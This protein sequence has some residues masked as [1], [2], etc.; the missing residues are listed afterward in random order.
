MDKAF[1]AVLQTEVDA[2]VIAKISYRGC[3]DRFRY[4]CL[5]CGEEVYLAAADSNE[6]AP[7]FRHRK[8]NNDTDCERYLGHPGALEYYVSVRKHN[9]EQVEFC[10]NRDKMT[11]EISVSFT[12]EELMEYEEKKSIMMV[13][14][15]YCSKPFRSVPLNKKVIVP[16]TKNYFTISEYSNGYLVSFDSGINKYAY[17]D[18]MRTSDKINIFRVRLEDEHC[19]HQTSEIVYTDTEYIAISEN[20]ENIQE[21]ASLDNIVSADDEFSFVTAGI[22]FYGVRFSIKQSD[23]SVMLFF[24][25]HNYQVETSESFSIL[26]PPVYTKDLKYICSDSRLYVDSSFKLVSHGNVNTDDSS[27]KELNRDV[28]ELHI[29]EE[30]IVYEKNINV[31][32]KKE[33]ESQV[34]IIPEEPE[35]IY[36]N[37]YVIPNQYDYFLFDQNGCTRLISGV[38]VYLSETDRIIGYKNRHIKVFVYGCPRKKVDTQQ[39]ISDILKYYSLSEVFNPDEFMNIESDKIVL[40]YLESCYRSGRINT[41]IKRYIKEGLF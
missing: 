17:H 22:T 7:H 35:I 37:K 30:V 13:F 15:Q 33:T 3:G 4:K 23:H 28:Q 1:D 19:R 12:E 11:F 36:S 5:C 24:Q 16:D 9:Q 2:A 29:A 40:E 8:G 10:F 6:R 20:E 38:T 26:W 34:E 39:L 31:C 18:V 25:K 32:I 27:I 21:L 14:T 41:V